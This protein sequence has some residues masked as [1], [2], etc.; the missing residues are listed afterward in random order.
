VPLSNT[1][2]VAEGQV[3]AVLLGG[4]ERDDDGVAAVVDFG[5]S[6]SRRARQ[7]SRARPRSRPS[8][9][10]LLAKNLLRDPRVVALGRVE[11]SQPLND[12]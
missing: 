3:R 4:T 8:R 9:S 7:G 2:S 6:C 10:R 1:A 12:P 5:P 11:L